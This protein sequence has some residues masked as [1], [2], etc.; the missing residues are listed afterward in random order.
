MLECS[1]RQLPRQL[2]DKP[3]QLVYQVLLD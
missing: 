2:N 3:Q 1:M